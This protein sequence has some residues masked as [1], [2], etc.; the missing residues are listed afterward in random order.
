MIS[1]QFSVIFNLNALHAKDLALFL[2]F[3]VAELLS[4]PGDKDLITSQVAGRS[5]VPTVRNPPTV[6]R[7]KQSR[8]QNPSN[9]VVDSLTGRIS[10]M[11]SFVA[12]RISISDAQR[13]NVT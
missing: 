13:R 9:S 11:T 2:N 10:L 7:N 4:S 6:I 5:M 1:T 3:W 8:V 12:T